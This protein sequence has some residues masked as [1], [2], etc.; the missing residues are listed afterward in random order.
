MIISIIVAVDEVGGIGIDNKIPWHLPADLKRFK[1]ITM[2]HHLLM[3]RKTFQSISSPLPGR[4]IIVLS[5][6]EDLKLEDCQITN[7]INSAIQ[8]AEDAGEKELFIAG[9]AEVYQKT[10]SIADHLYLTRVHCQQK[11]DAYFPVLKDADWAGICS[12][13]H[14]ADEKNEH[15]HTF[16][17]YIKS[18]T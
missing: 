10:L 7:T 15:P 5:R 6:N 16:I 2:G 13:Y 4:K 14:P 11:A 8:L 18:K 1:T 12:Q 3:G 17:H 9:G